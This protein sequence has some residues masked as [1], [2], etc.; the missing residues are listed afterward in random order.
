[1]RGISSLLL[2]DCILVEL[3]LARPAMASRKE[4]NG[5]KEGE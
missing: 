5:E 2:V 3:E 4:Q 1:M